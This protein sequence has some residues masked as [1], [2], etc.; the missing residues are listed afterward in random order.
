LWAR[1]ACAHPTRLIATL[2]QK[3]IVKVMGQL[4]A[5]DRESLG[6]VIQVILG[7]P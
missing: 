1:T 3:Q 5:T 7:D 6:K 4:S 2:E